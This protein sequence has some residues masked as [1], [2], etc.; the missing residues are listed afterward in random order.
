MPGEA[1]ADV[2]RADPGGTM[3][4]EAEAGEG[5][6][7]ANPTLPLGRVLPFFP[8]F[9][10]PSSRLGL[11]GAMQAAT[12]RNARKETAASPNTAKETTYIAS[13]IAQM[14]ERYGGDC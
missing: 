6:A 4:G 2:P 10:L 9:P 1:E 13:V 7:R 3:P 14:W 12:P 8:P 5:E 11:F